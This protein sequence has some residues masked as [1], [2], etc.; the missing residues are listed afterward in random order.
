VGSG[1]RSCHTRA[2]GRSAVTFDL[3]GTL[4]DLRSVYIRAHQLAAR[5]VLSRELE[6]A[7]VLELMETGMPIRAHMALLDEPAAD[8]LVDVL[9]SASA[10]P[11]SAGSTRRTLAAWRLSASR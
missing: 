11:T 5:E 8:R 3:D 10:G 6:E 7:H 1:A 9:W 4:V 2:L